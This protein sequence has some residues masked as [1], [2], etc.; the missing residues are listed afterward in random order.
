[1]RKQT[2]ACFPSFA[3]GSIRV[4][5]RVHVLGTTGVYSTVWPQYHALVPRTGITKR[6][7]CHT[8]IAILECTRV[9]VQM[10]S[11]GRSFCD[12]GHMSILQINAGRNTCTRI[13][14]CNTYRGPRTVYSG[15]MLVHVFLLQY[16][17]HVC[18]LCRLHSSSLLQYGHIT[19]TTLQQTSKFAFVLLWLSSGA[20]C[21][22]K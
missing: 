17:C 6:L 14:Q 12:Y 16:C 3:S 8:D 18:L 13:L 1:M 9:P 22:I 5:T 15:S 21:N 7:Q 11:V 2:V 10:S 4:F 19:F 20:Y